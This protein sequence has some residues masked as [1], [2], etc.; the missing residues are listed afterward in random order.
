MER[1]RWITDWWP[2]R[3]NLKILR[4]NSP[5]SNP[6]TGE[7]FDYRKEIETLDYFQLKEDLKKLMTDSQDW[8]PADFGHYGPLFIRL[9]W[10]SAGSYRVFDGRGGARNGDIRFAPRYDWPDAT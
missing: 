5:E 7:N 8:W 2:H 9:A 3:L 4:Q 6:Y 1:K 10:H